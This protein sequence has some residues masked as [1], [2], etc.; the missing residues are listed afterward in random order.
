MCIRDRRQIDRQTDRTGNSSRV[1]NGILCTR[2]CLLIPHRKRTFMPPL[3]TH[4][5]T[6][7]M[8]SMLD[9]SNLSVINRFISIYS[10]HRQWFLYL[11]FIT[12]KHKFKSTLLIICFMSCY[13][14]FQIFLNYDVIL[15]IKRYNIAKL[16]C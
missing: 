1:H 2:C 12:T 10:I 7:K 8:P 6:R 15:D 3:H 9:Q 16:E 13:I 14:V 11:L 4:S 5:H